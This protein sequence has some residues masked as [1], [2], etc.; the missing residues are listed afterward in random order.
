MH[1]YISDTEYAVAHLTAALVTDRAELARLEEEQRVALAKESYF[2]IAFLQRQMH[3]SANYWYGQLREA[4]GDRTAL[5]SEIARIQA[6][7]M[8]KRFS[9][10]ALASALLQIAKQGI[11]VVR[12]NPASCPDG[13]LI[14]G[15][16]LKWVIWS[17]RNQALHYEEPRMVNAE[18]YNNLHTM[19]QNGGHPLL[20]EARSGESLSL[21][22]VEHLGWFTFEAYRD[23]MRSLIG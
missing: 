14:C 7:L 3:P 10:S 17:G 4:Q 23:D 1:Q 2:D 9:L 18:T 20:L 13:R 15:V 5:D 16:P 6:R 11:S 12:R 22:V 19:G 8:D 21:P